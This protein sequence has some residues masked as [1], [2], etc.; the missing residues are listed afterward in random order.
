MCFSRGASCEDALTV[1]S[2]VQTRDCDV[3]RSSHTPKNEEEKR[4]SLP[5]IVRPLV[6]KP[7][8]CFLCGVEVASVVLTA[9]R[10]SERP[11]KKVNIYEPTPVFT[12]EQKIYFMDK[13][14]GYSVCSQNA[15]EVL[16]KS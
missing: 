13:H 5:V 2:F 11:L 8:R 7:V 10:I 12:F 4:T 3:T 1:R 6:T 15:N 9:V 16:E 14:F